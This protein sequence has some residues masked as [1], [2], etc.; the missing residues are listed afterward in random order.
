MGREIKFSLVYRDMWQSSGK[1]QPRVDQLVRIA[2]EIINMGCFARVETNGGGFEQVNLLYGENPNK[3]VRA[4]TKPFHEA[5]IQTH[6]LDRA[7]NGL[8]M[9]PVPVDVRK[10][11]YKVK[12]AQGVDITRCFCGLNDTRNI[13]DSIKYAKEA[14]MIAQATMCLTVSKV[15]TVEYYCNLA[16]ELVAGGADEICMKDMAGIGRPVSLGKIV[17]YIKSKYPNIT[18]QYHGQTGPGFTPASILEVAK[19]GC[20]IIDVGMEPLSWGT[21]HADVIMVREM[22]KDAGFDVP[23]INM[24]AYMRARTLTQE[25]MDDFL[26]YYIPESN[27]RLTS[28]L[29]GCGL[30]GGMMGSLMNDLTTNLESINK[31]RAKQGKPAYTTDDLMV[32][33]FDEVAYVWPRVGFPP[34]VTPFSQYVK[35]L[36]LFNLMQLEKGKERWTMIADN[37]WDMILGKS[38]KL[39]GEVAPE[40]KELAAKQ[41]REFFTGNP[42]DLYPDKLDE[43]RKEMDANGWEYGQDDEE[44]FELAMHPE[45]YR[46][47]K[48]GKAKADFE[49][50]LAAKKAAKAN[51][52]SLKPQSLTVDVNGEKY[53]VTVSYDAP[54]ADAPKAAAAAAPS[55]PVSGNATDVIAPI[56]GK[57]FKTKDSSSK[58]VAVGDMVKEGDIVGYIEAM[59]VFNAVAAPASGKV[60]E[61]C[62]N[63][64]D[65]VDEDDVLMKIQ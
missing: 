45:Q 42:Q 17:S 19:A 61:I 60:V 51:V 34:L 7:L 26:G 28:L 30:P 5:G 37:I 6:M 47:Y 50:D 53:A 24:A 31:S 56:S 36:A 3:S 62:R 11:F 21:G 32:K 1:Y 40:L 12:K 63:S 44:L 33:M 64:G 39:P 35:N 14:G 4:W 9:S 8:R 43:F 57:F 23:E 13:I 2:P 49:A 58:A 41:G 65:D 48:S 15:H 25:F 20:D 10:L 52:G 29:I 46:A 38:G 27:R 16:D 18:I 55:A 22:L 59:K 54:K